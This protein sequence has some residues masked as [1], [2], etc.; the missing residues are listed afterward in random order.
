MVVFTPS[1][2]KD[3]FSHRWETKSADKISSICN[4]LESPGKIKFLLLNN[5]P[6]EKVI[7]I[8]ESADVIVDDL[9]AGAFRLSALEGSGLGKA[10]IT[11]LDN[12]TLIALSEAV[13]VTEMPFINITF[14]NLEEVLLKLC[15]YY[16]LIK[17]IGDYSK[18]WMQKYYYSSSIL[19]KKITI[20]YQGFFN[21]ERRREN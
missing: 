14:E 18:A 15:N 8:K 6:F 2:L 11:F 7:K 1:N 9:S 3:A 16:S 21:K 17:Q 19:I 10:T 13:G 5:P 20:L 12:S 4:K